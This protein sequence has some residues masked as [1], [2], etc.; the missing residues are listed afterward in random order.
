LQ[1]TTLFP[2]ARNAAPVNE[3]GQTAVIASVQATI[4]SMPGVAALGR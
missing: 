2:A 3:V 4:T 1:K